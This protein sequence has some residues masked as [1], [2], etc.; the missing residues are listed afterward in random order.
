MVP[1]TSHIQ[2]VADDQ[3][4]FPRISF[5][6]ALEHLA[7]VEGALGNYLGLQCCNND[8]PCKLYKHWQDFICAGWLRPAQGC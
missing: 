2:S 7:D 1:D 4:R 6:K 3:A 5:S 8:R